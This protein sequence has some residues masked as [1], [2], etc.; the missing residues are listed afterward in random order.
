MARES[1]GFNND[2]SRS[3]S[4][5]VLCIDETLSE[6]DEDNSFRLDY[7]PGATVTLD[8]TLNST[9]L[10]IPTLSNLQTQLSDT[11]AGFDQYESKTGL[12]YSELRGDG[13]V[14]TD[15]VDDFVEEKMVLGSVLDRVEEM[16]NETTVPVSDN[17]EP[18]SL[19]QFYVSNFLFKLFLNGFFV[20]DCAG[21]YAR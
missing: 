6:E 9:M 1:D 5:N 12:F 19:E 7:K 13:I 21:H 3:P 2:G 14:K 17:D 20:L 15:V 11:Q 10:D 8:A 18:T 16:E 4:P